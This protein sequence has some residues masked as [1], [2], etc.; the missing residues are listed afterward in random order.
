MVDKNK[1]IDTKIVLLKISAIAAFVIGSFFLVYSTENYRIVDENIISLSVTILTVIIGFIL[2]LKGIK[3]KFLKS[4]RAV[5]VTSWLVINFIATP[6]FLFSAGYIINGAFDQQDEE[7]FDVKVEDAFKKYLYGNKGFGDKYSYQAKIKHWRKTPE[8]IQLRLNKDEY[9]ELSR[10]KKG[11]YITVVTK[12][13][14][15]N[16][17]WVV[18]STIN[19]VRKKSKA[20]TNEAEENANGLSL[21]EES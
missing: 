12:P 14:L 15:F 19:P 4:Y 18:Q 21:Y 17:E 11:R 7:T 1:D 20:N 10:I 6:Y 16:E 5:D 8:F 13:G 9:R 2:I 3:S